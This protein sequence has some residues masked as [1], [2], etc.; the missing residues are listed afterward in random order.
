MPDLNLK[1]IL[2]PGIGQLGTYPPR[3]LLLPAGGKG[4]RGST[5]SLPVISIIV[6]SLNQGR[7]IG[8]TLRSIVEQDYPNLE[9]IVVDGGSTDNSLAVIE[10]FEPHIAWWV[11]E[12]DGGQAAAI[13]KGFQ[14]S[15]GEIMAWI[16]SDDC[17]APGALC[18]VAQY[19]QTH[20]NT[21]VLYGNRILID[22][23]GGE[24]GRWILPR[25]SEKILKW[26]DYVPQETLYW[27]RSAWLAAG[28]RLDESF[29]FAMDWDILLRFSAQGLKMERIPGFLGLFRIHQAQKTLSDMAST[30]KEEMQK[31]RCRELGF[32][33]S[34]RQLLW[35]TA[36]YLLAAKFHEIKYKL[37]VFS[38]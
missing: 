15:T 13:N 26:A 7:F 2:R 4:C 36:P 19:F 35:N 30:G 17:V 8:E 6:P 33:P 11:S 24:I 18:R 25:H 23:Q 21:E 12:P 5:S 38:A 20:P 34:H 9:L 37:G 3:K 14:K 31:L 22:E 27:R 1:K 29:C 32:A 16:N 10:E 28:G